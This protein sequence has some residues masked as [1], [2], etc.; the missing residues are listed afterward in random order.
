MMEK[1]NKRYTFAGYDKLDREKFADFLL[2]LMDERDNY[3]RDPDDSGAYCIAIDGEY[4]SGKTRFLQMF[5]SYLKDKRSGY[6]ILYYNAWEHD[7]FQDALSS[8]IYQ[9]GHDDMFIDSQKSEELETRREKVHTIAKVALN[10]IV[11]V[12]AKKVFGEESEEIVDQIRDAIAGKLTSDK[13]STPYDDRRKSLNALTEALSDYTSTYPLLVI[14]DELDRCAPDFAVQTFETAKHLL[15]VPNTIFLFTVDMRQMTAAVRK[16]YGQ[17]IDADGYICKIFD[18][19]AVFPKQSKNR[20]ISDIL[21]SWNDGRL[22]ESKHLLLHINKLL[23]RPT[24][25]L[26]TINTILQSFRIMWNAFLR[27]YHSEDA[28]CFY[29]S[30]L[31]L[32][33]QNLNFYNMLSHSTPIPPEIAKEILNLCEGHNTI[34]QLIDK[35]YRVIDGASKKIFGNRDYVNKVYEKI[36]IHPQLD[37]KLLIS[38]ESHSYKRT[39]V[40]SI[41]ANFDMLLYY[42]DLVH[43]DRIKYLTYGQYIHCQ[44]EMFNFSQPAAEQEDDQ[45]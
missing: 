27:E 14:I 37:S 7:I 22:N 19:I 32:K 28:Y 39:F 42:P 1:Q 43:Y 38:E 31:Y 33:Y 2:H 29:F 44:L 34:K 41:G 24:C 18:Y 5:Q 3:R 4:G 23:N 8:F 35:H 11:A 20:Y 26:R 13:V 16:V 30:C 25:S 15:N 10:A 6:S 40:L 12:G 9:I 17:D 21:N 45:S 36:S